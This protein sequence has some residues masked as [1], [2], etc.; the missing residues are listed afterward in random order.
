MS[1]SESGACLH[2]Y[3]ERRMAIIR[4]AKAAASTEGATYDI[5]TLSCCVPLEVEYEFKET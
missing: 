2:G 4:A 1:V 3:D 5:L